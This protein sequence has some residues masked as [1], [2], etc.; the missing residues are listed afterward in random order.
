MFARRLTC[1]LLCVAALLAQPS[2]IR[3][4]YEVKLSGPLTV[5]DGW[6]ELRAESPLKAEKSLQYVVLYLEPPYRQDF[7]GV[8]NG[9]DKG[10]GILMPDGGVMNP[11][12]VVVDEHG[13]SFPL[14]YA[15]AFGDDPK[16]SVPYPAEFPRDR[17][18]TTVRIRSARPFK[19]RSIYWY[20]DSSKDWK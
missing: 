13:N 14:V 6:V 1:A 17:Q 9:P 11:E 18:Y 8:G 20:C 10:K 5:G 3:D 19:C 7:D 2:C 16:Y 12:I 4:S 15:G